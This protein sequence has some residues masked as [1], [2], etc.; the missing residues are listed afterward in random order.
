MKLAW[1]ATLLTLLAGCNGEPPLDSPADA[2]P[3]SSD[4]PDAPALSCGSGATP[5]RSDEVSCGSELCS[6]ATP[7]CCTFRPEGV[8]GGCYVASCV[9]SRSAASECQW[10]TG[11]DE[12]TDCAADELCCV[13]Q[14]MLP[15]GRR[16][17]ETTCRPASDP[18]CAAQ[19]EDDSE[20][21]A[22][23][24]FCVII[25]TDDGPLGICR[26]ERS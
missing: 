20:C 1:T 18:D 7:L 2:D 17:T 14:R 13:S 16:G 5:T 10:I 11:C 19:C 4:T 26:S 23:I 15:D 3:P 25:N 21:A 22:P 9:E 24:P 6:G 8:A 12:R